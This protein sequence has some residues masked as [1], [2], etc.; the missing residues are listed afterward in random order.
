MRIYF[1]SLF[2]CFFAL[3]IFAQQGVY[4]SQNELMLIIDDQKSTTPQGE[5]IF[6]TQGNIIFSGNSN[7]KKDIVFKTDAQSIFQKNKANVFTKTGANA[8]WYIAEGN[9]Y[10]KDVAPLNIIINAQQTDGFY[11]FYSGINDS[12]LA[13]IAEPATYSPALMFAL[14]QILWQ[15]YNL[16]KAFKEKLEGQKTTKASPQIASM[17]PT[18]G[19]GMPWLWDGKFLYPAYDRNPMLVWQFTNNILKPRQ[20]PVNNEEWRW[21][22]DTLKPY[23]GG[24]PSREWS[25]R[26]GILR[27]V[28]SNNMNNEYIIDNDNIARPRFGNFG[29]NEWQINGNIPLPV[30]TAVLLGIVYR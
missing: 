3:S 19:N 5:V 26:G 21:D 4:N 28:W 8:N 15:S 7:E 13:Y 24:H 23:W 29:E 14:T 11:A 6:S 22:G 1:T 16:D 12:L 30:I 17:T 20:L 2:I 18:F 9:F 25:W 10:Y 27:Q